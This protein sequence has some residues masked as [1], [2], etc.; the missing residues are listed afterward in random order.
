MKDIRQDFS[1][2][3]QFNLFRKKYLIL[4]ILRNVI[5]VTV[6][7]IRSTSGPEKQ[8]KHCVQMT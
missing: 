3:S 2:R 6:W 5:I 4:I 7:V 1:T 8:N